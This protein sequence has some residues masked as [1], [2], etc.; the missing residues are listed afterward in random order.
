MC[1]IIVSGT[2]SI[3]AQTLY[4]NSKLPIETRVNDLLKQMTLEDKVAQM[5]QY[6]GLEHIKN[7]EKKRAANNKLN[8]DAQAFY[9]NVSVSEI[10]KKIAAGQIGSF[11]HV[12]TAKEA[13]Y[14]QALAQKSRLKIPLLIGIDAIHGNGMVKG[15]TVFPSPISISSS[16]D[17]DIQKEIA[18][19][20]A[21]E[22]KATGSQWAFSP[23]LDIARDPRWG[24]IGETFGE[25]PYLVSQMGVATIN[26]LQTSG[27]AASAK[28]LIA[29][30]Q[31]V[32]GLNKAPTDIS[33]RTLEEIFLPPY[34]AAVAANVMTIMPAHNE[35]NGVPSHANG[36]LMDGLLRKKWGFKGF[37]ISDWMDIER[38]AN[39][40][41]T[42]ANDK[43]AVLA[44]VSAGMD[45]H[46]HG[47]D[48]YEYILQL[49]KEGKLS[50]DR[51]TASAR[52]ILEVKFKV[53]LFENPFVDETKQVIF[54][55]EHQNIALS[56]ARKSIVLLKNDNI[57]PL[58]TGKYKRI[59]V[60]GPNADN[61][62]ML[63]DWS[64]QQPDENVTT[65]FEGIKA[66]A[67]KDCEVILLNSGRF[68]PELNDS[69]LNDVVKQAADFDLIIA[70]VGDNSL[71]FE[72]NKRTAGENT[73]FDDIILPGLQ[74]QFLKDLHALGKPIIAVMVNG[75][76]LAIPWLE[77]NLPAIVEAW[78]PGSFGGQAIAEILFG[79]VNPSG[80]LTVS[81]LRNVGQIGN[82][83]NHRPSQYAL[84]YIGKAT[85]PLYPFGFGLSYTNY[86]YANVQLDKVTI[87]DSESVKLSVQVTNTGEMDGDEIVQ[88]YLNGSLSA[89]SKPVKELKG[90]QRISLKAG[91]TKKVEF[92]L[93]PV[94]FK[95]Y[96]I[97]MN[98]SVE[99]GE[100]TLMVGSSSLDKDLTAVK[101]QI[102]K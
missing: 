76:P 11:L 15:S 99:P 98:Y 21:I 25:D 95:N 9:P 14:L 41:R 66:A 78:E 49:V 93:P 45:M 16:W 56:A 94:T 60:T 44:S 22:M 20:T 34:E 51:V 55:K 86:S 67:P 53:G 77:E 79:Q 19:I 47:P 85:G 74:P 50:E 87:R 30:S 84:K 54:S 32:N 43:D 73:D 37:Y 90:F 64:Q 69:L 100:F 57:L 33:D 6:V 31:P 4:Q 27:V 65:V 10:E 70:V 72:G 52:R 18:K 42:V 91:E 17:I 39:L 1:L 35:L 83:Y 80:K 63:G 88:L 29:G 3:C 89:V 28:H 38:M 7:A 61:Q 46:M 24:R 97:N 75:R 8:N 71:R 26:G 36:S 23:N 48:F 68:I 12:L 13:N 40:H 81:M 5:C 82:Y 58:K 101:L 92:N 59:L 96:D 2:K 62:A 102:T